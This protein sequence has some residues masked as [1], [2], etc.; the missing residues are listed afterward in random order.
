MFNN[1][2][3]NQIIFKVILLSILFNYSCFA[4]TESCCMNYPIVK[5]SAIK[6]FELKEGIFDHAFHLTN[7][8]KWNMKISVPDIKEAEKVPLVIALHWAGDHEAYKEFS[9]CLAFPALDFLNAIIIAPSAEGRHWIEP[10]NEKRVIALIKQVRKY[11]PIDSEKIIVTGYS[12]GGIGTWHYAK[13]YPKLFCA[14]LPMS[15]HY[16][17]KHIKVPLYVLHGEKDELFKVE[18]V[19]EVL[20][21]AIKKGSQIRYEIIPN[22]THYAA[23]SFVDELKKMAKWMKADIWN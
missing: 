21:N 8:E 13:I 7:D 22:F 11:W 12:N 17:A 18:E 9:N 14:A 1:I 20:K 15:G 2:K 5:K 19:E 23:C 6:N 4:Q 3:I 16:Q 10:M